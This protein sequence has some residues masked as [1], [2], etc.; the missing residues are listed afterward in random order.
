MKKRVIFMKMLIGYLLQI[1]TLFALA[2]NA[3]AE[4]LAGRYTELS[5]SC[6]E[7]NFADFYL[8]NDGS[9]SRYEWGCQAT[10]ITEVSKMDALLIDGNCS[11][12]GEP[13]GTARIFIASMGQDTKNVLVYSSGD[14]LYV[15]AII[16][17]YCGQ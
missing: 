2:A 17:K 3:Q 4:I 5:N 10:K 6:L 1:I 16:W 11:G 15:D 8:Q 14:A 13:M 9:F 12:E 7:P